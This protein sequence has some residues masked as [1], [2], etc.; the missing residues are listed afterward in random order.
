MKKSNTTYQP[1]CGDVPR[2]PKFGQSGDP[3]ETAW[4]NEWGL[5]SGFD[6]TGRLSRPFH[7]VDVM[8]ISTVIGTEYSTIACRDFTMLNS[9]TEQSGMSHNWE[10]RVFYRVNRGSWLVERHHV[11]RTWRDSRGYPPWVHF[12][13]DLVM[14]V[15]C[16]FH[17][18]CP[19][20]WSRD[21]HVRMMPPHH[22]RPAT[23]RSDSLPHI[24][25]L[26]VVVMKYQGLVD[27]E[28]KPFGNVLPFEV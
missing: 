4:P 13:I 7:R 1:F 21:D 11:G 5:R 9:I 8:S 18:S 28:D 25:C 14:I 24:R 27:P 19:W 17:Q 10:W 16:V 26:L 12:L 3:R 22:V 2:D 15:W 6:G 23:K 20:P